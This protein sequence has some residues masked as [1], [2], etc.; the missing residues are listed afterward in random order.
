MAVEIISWSISTIVWAG[1][2]LN[3]WPWICSLID[4]IHRV[5]HQ[6]MGQTPNIAAVGTWLNGT[7]STYGS[8]PQ[9]LPH[10]YRSSVWSTDRH[11]ALDIY[12]IS[13]LHCPAPVKF[14]VKVF[15]LFNNCLNVWISMYWGTFNNVLARDFMCRAHSGAYSHSMVTFNSY[16]KTCLK[17]PL[18][19]RH[20]KDLYDK[21]LLTFSRNS[22]PYFF[23]KIIKMSQKVSSAAVV[24]GALRVKRVL[25]IAVAD[26]GPLMLGVLD[27]WTPT[28]NILLTLIAQISFHIELCPIEARY[29]ISLYTT[30]LSIWLSGFRDFFSIYFV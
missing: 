6:T 17:R 2:L 29:S 21:W 27:R 11:C 14:R 13:Y 25:W 22:I 8:K 5:T 9:M 15:E 28:V 20:N 4:K 18:K 16:S 19:N 7:P 26:P 30:P 12:K 23:R 3:S 1:P 24:I 10:R